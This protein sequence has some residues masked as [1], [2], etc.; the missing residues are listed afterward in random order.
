MDEPKTTRFRP[1][2]L[3]EIR[4]YL[5]ERGS[6]IDAEAFH[7]Y[8][9]CRGWRA[10]KVKMKNWKAAVVTWEKSGYNDG[11]KGQFSTLQDWAA[12]HDMNERHGDK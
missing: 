4:A 11:R 8:Y 12:T 1:P 5:Q 3:D 9:E 2:T 10:G 6:K 7:A